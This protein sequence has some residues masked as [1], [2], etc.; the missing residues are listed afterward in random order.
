MKFLIFVSVSAFLA[1]AYSQ[2]LETIQPLVL[3]PSIEAVEVKQPRPPMVIEEN[4][5]KSNVDIVEKIVQNVINVSKHKPD[6]EYFDGKVVPTPKYPKGP[7][8]N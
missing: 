6:V 2:P 4:P 3:K 1:L 5:S 7:K 8:R